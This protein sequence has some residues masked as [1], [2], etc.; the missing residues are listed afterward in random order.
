MLDDVR[1]W[2]VAHT[3][4]AEVG[5]LM[6]V[7]S[8]TSLLTILVLIV[9]TILVLKLITSSTSKATTVTTV[10]CQDRRSV[11]KFSGKAPLSGIMTALKCA[12]HAPNHFLT[13]PWR[14]RL[15][16]NQSKVTLGECADKFTST[17]AFA[18]VPDFVV[19]SIAANSKN[20]G[21]EE[22][23]VNGL[24]DHAACACAVQ[25]FM[26]SC[27]SQGIGT[28]WMTGKMGVSGTDMLHKVC[29]VNE[30]TEEHYMG[31]ILVGMP[32]VPMSS[33]K[34]PS[35]KTGL[36]DPVFAHTN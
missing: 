18:S 33:M 22:W 16:G 4:S 20:K 34:V 29:R 17:G 11:E 26:L 28:K 14:F 23:N 12:I 19:V 2:F 32:S 13:E 25:N 30:E 27:A 35:R 36:S 3:F 1:T 21:F 15:L 9:A 10:V 7:L 5:R 8:E 6:M 24:E 31:T